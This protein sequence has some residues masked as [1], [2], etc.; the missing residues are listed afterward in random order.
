MRV[1]QSSFQADRLPVPGAAGAADAAPS[2]C[3]LEDPRPAERCVTGTSSQSCS[4]VFQVNSTSSPPARSSRALYRAPSS[5]EAVGGAAPP[6][7][8]LLL[9]DQR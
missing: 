5:T 4:S 2:G 7:P 9:R 6:A 8:R 3:E 1:Y